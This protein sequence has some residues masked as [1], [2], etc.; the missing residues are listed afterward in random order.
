MAECQSIK[1]KELSKKPDQYPILNLSTTSQESEELESEV[2]TISSEPS[3]SSKAIS[4]G[5]LKLSPEKQ[6]LLMSSIMPQTINSLE[7]K[8]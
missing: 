4:T 5:H 2:A 6:E 7:L 1:K 3:D 8:L